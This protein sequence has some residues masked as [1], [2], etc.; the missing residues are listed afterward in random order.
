MTKVCKNCK[1]WAKDPEVPFTGTCKN[2]KFITDCF[3]QDYEG[4]SIELVTDAEFG[5]LHW[6]PRHD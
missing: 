6:T 3:Y 2:S 1:H 4:Y 5:C